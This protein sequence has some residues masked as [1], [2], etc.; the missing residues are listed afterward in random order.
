M[1]FTTHRAYRHPNPAPRSRSGISVQSAA[2]R[3]VAVGLSVLGVALVALVAS[4]PGSPFQP[5]LP[6]GSGASGPFRWLADVLGLG[7]LH[8]DPLA[9][10]GIA[11]AAFA[12]G[13]FLLVLREAWNGR[14]AL[15][16]VVWL[17]LAFHVVVLML[18]LLFS[19]DVYSYAYYGRIASVHH[20]NPYVATPVDFPADP[21]APDR[22]RAERPHLVVGGSGTVLLLFLINAIFRG[23]GDAVQLRFGQFPMEAIALADGNLCD[24]PDPDLQGS[25][26]QLDCDIIGHSRA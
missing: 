1:C 9:C 4:T 20:A 14:L 13:S 5:V 17:T 23:T 7:S 3:R 12:A 10:V 2:M 8:G 18:P 21:L 24:T 15:R 11:A 16:K 22:R 19:R 6:A 25:P 26:P